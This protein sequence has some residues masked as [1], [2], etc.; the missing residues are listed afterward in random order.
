MENEQKL[1]NAL[2][3]VFLAK[4]LFEDYCQVISKIEGIEPEIIKKRVLDNTEI[5][6]Q[7]FKN[8]ILP[9]PE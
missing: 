1:A 9:K 2:S 4:A 5:K 7:N 3:G 6:I 8:E